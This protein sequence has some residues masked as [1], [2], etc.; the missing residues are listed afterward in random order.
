MQTNWGNLHTYTHKSIDT[1][2]LATPLS[3]QVVYK[4]GI[5]LLLGLVIWEDVKGPWM[6]ARNS[7]PDG[8][9]Y[10]TALLTNWMGLI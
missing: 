2:T 1:P 9:L 8:T 5:T 10:N 3:R 4:K 7:A 6:C